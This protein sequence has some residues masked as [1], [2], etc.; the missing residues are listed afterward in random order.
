[1]SFSINLFLI[2]I[3]KNPQYMKYILS[4]IFLVIGFQLAQSQ[5]TNSWV[6]KVSYQATQQKVDSITY[7]TD[8][9][10]DMNPRAVFDSSTLS[11]TI[12]SDFGIGDIYSRKI[13]YTRDIV[14]GN[15]ITQV[16]GVIRFYLG[17]YVIV[18]TS[19][20]VVDM[21]IQQKSSRKK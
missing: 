2:S 16:D 19:P 13:V 3:V 17:R 14:N 7:Y 10:I 1:M 20:F 11:I 15:D 12:G 6:Y 4:L 8:V 9:F 5:N 18:P 21:A